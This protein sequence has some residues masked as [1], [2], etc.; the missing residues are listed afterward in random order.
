VG[1]S[2][3][4]MNTPRAKK[5]KA[6]ILKHAS[7]KYVPSTPKPKRKNASED[8]DSRAEHADE[9][10]RPR[11]ILAKAKGYAQN[12]SDYIRS[13]KGRD[14]Y[15]APDEEYVQEVFGELNARFP[16]AA[17]P[18][19]FDP[20]ATNVRTGRPVGQAH[21]YSWEGHHILPASAF[22]VENEDGPP[23]T[24]PQ[25][26][27]LLRT[28]YDVNNG[29]NIIFLPAESVAVPIHRLLQHPTDH[30]E[31]T[32]LV[33]GQM[34][35]LAKK[36]AKQKAGRKHK[37]AIANLFQRLVDLEDDNWDFLVKLG[38]ATV[39]AVRSGRS[40]EEAVVRFSS[41]KTKYEYGALC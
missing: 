2:A 1:L 35:T 40:V 16:D 37:A 29:H 18:Q 7:G 22:Y 36:L 20:G 10:L 13:L 39:T 8:K 23:F 17:A 41:K 25:Y 30:P 31:Y 28:N 15:Q 38:R 9:K 12:G 4:E 34:Q 6:W 5:R 21:P 14:V 19:N 24:G 27:L 26:Q 3:K 32:Q 33:I 11:T